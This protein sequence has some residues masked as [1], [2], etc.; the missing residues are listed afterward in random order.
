[1]NKKALAVVA[2]A[3]TISVGG[4]AVSEAATKSAGKNVAGTTS[5]A[6]RPTIGGMN[7]NHGPSVTLTTVLAG[8]VTKG[9][10]TQAQ[11][12]AISA[13]YKSAEDAEHANMP[14]GAPG[15]GKGNGMGVQFD[16][17]AVIL[18]TLGI[19]ATTL[20][21]QLQ[22]GKSLADIAGT[23]KDALI[24]ALVAAETKAIDAAVTAGTL[25]AANAATLKSNLTAHVTAEVSQAGFAGGQGMGKIGRAHV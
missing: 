11:S 20:T 3:A 7:G 6:T 21:T 17:Q 2:L 15:Q 25:T 8:L 5:T 4:V 10:I 14:A 13:A 19:D 18:S 24:A 12:D 22:A 23:K 1:M 16:K 9:T